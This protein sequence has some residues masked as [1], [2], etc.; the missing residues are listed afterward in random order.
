M[1]ILGQYLNS[2]KAIVSPL[3]AFFVGTAFTCCAYALLA[4]IIA[5][6]LSNE[7]ISTSLVGIILSL[8]YVGYI[9]ASMTSHII[10]NKVGHI[11]SFSAYISIFSALVLVHCFSD[12][13]YLWGVLRFAEGYCL[14]SAMMCLESWLNTRSNNK[15]RGVIMSLYM[16]TTYLGAGLGQLMLNIPDHSG[17]LIYIIVSVLFSIALVPISLTALPSPDITTYKSMSLLKLYKIT[18]VGVLSCIT[19][20]I[21]VGMFYTLGIIYTHKMGLDIK[22]TSLFMFFG[23]L[24][25][26]LAQFPIGK[27]SDTM[28]RRY[29]LMI[30][31][32]I[33]FFAVP[34]LHFI[35]NDGKYELAIAA[36][37]MGSG[38]FVLYPISVSHVND[39]IED[40]ER[41]HASGLLILLQSI[42]LVVGPIVVSFFMQEFGAISFVF[43]Y[44]VVTGVFVIFALKHIIVK[45]NINYLNVTKTDPIPMSP[46]HAFN[47]LSQDDDL[48]KK[49]KELFSSKH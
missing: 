41:V 2:L 13:P 14:G 30:C 26:L 20:G 4:S 7:G 33:M 45:P 43:S 40:T 23:V 8:Y 39:L 6:R 17:F 37:L 42:G 12:N 44:S 29:V 10:I 34:G 11:R 18:P 19:S 47:E 24:G 32:A 1:K 38:T 25:G 9:F 27:L 22:Q 5:V 36:M 35:V 49:V 48:V 21:L 46:T 16:I 3:T 15:N 28:D 31:C